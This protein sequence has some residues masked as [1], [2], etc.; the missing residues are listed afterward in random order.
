MDKLFQITTSWDDAHALDKKVAA[1][2]HKY[3]VQGTFYLSKNMSDRLTESDIRELAKEQEI[4]AHTI[5][6][7][8]LSRMSD[9][10]AY[11][12]ILDS[13]KW[14]ESIIGS[15]V[16]MFCYPKGMFNERTPDLVRKAGFI[17]ARTVA[18]YD[19]RAPADPFRLGTT[20]NVYPFPFRKTA[21]YSYYWRYLLQPLAQN[22]VSLKAFKVP[23]WKYSGWLP[24]AKAVFDYSLKNGQ[25]FHLWGHSWEIEKFGMWQD[26]EQM[27]QYISRRSGCEYVVNSRLI[28]K[29]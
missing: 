24:I 9:G 8:D 25:V 28:E 7:P 16:K 22:H 20:I 23:F 29:K 19:I 2:L 17:G 5:T 11:A 4:G 12:E 14:L 18:K 27:L 10:A 3:A 1:L 21:V 26:L 15:E 13:K 6:H